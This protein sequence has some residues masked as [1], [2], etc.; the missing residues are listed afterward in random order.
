M[1]GGP[2]CASGTPLHREGRHSSHLYPCHPGV[3]PYPAAAGPVNT[4]GRQALLLLPWSAL[5]V[6]EKQTPKYPNGLG[7]S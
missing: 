7:V 5:L 1:G 3:L 6:T 4:E 2:G